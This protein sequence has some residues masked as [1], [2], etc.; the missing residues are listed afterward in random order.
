VPAAAAK[1]V[2]PSIAMADVQQQLTGLL[3]QIET[4]WSDNVLRELPDRAARNSPAAQAFA[5]HYDALVDGLRPVT[6]VSSSF[7]GDAREG[8]LVVTGQIVLDVRDG[9]NR[10]RR[11]A[12]VAEFADRNGSPALVRL[13]LP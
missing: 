4:G 5:R 6:V 13:S 12:L 8:R 2:S 7:H 9:A 1:P 11:L 3:Q 10:T